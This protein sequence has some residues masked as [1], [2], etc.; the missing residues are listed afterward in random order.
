VGWDYQFVDR[1]AADA[2][3]RLDLK[4]DWFV[5]EGTAFPPPELRRSAVSTLLVDGEQYPAAAYGNRAITLV[6]K[7]KNP[8]DLDAVAAAKQALLRELDR[9]AGIL[10]YRPGTSEPV[11]FRTFRAGPES[12][13]WTAALQTLTAVIPAEPF[14]YGLK[15]SL[16]Q[17]TVYADPAEGVTLNANPFAETDASDWTAFGGTIARSTAQAHQGSASLLLTPSGSAA[18]AEATTSYVPVTAGRQYRLSAWVRCDAAREVRVMVVWSDGSTETGNLGTT[19][20]VAATTWTLIDTVVTAPV[21]AVQG[22][23]AVAMFSTPPASHLL[24]FDE[25]RVRQVGTEGGLHFNVTDVKGD[26]ETPLHLRLST[27]TV[28]RQPVFAVRRRGTPSAMPFVLQA[29]SMT[30]ATDTALAASNDPAMSGAGQNYLRVS[31]ATNTSMVA[32]ASINPWPAAPSGDVRGT[33]R[34]LAR[35]RRNTGSDA[36]NLQ[37]TWGNGTGANVSGDIV[38]L[39]TVGFTDPIYVDLGFVQF[40]TGQ[41]PVTDMSGEVLP[42]RGMQIVLQAQRATGAGSLDIDFLAFV[43]ADDRLMIATIHPDFGG[44]AQILDSARTML[45]GVGSAGEVRPAVPAQIVGGPP[46]VSPGQTN[47][48]VYLPNILSGASA[49][50][51]DTTQVTP[52][53]WP[54]YLH[55]RPVAS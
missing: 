35:V 53:Y 10:R 27:S 9:P 29:E 1:I 34:V 55:V 54:R 48:I 51:T 46:M 28:L 4:A 11:F 31:F 7:A 13:R 37:L 36:I 41:D 33:Y 52:F 39:P 21:G 20:A 25:A 26:V 45:Y 43:P 32:R 18:S 24:Y 15:E 6:L 42:V 2:T 8:A 3:V 47:R 16:P 40:P 22:R 12:I 50:V 38:A 49:A 5:D 19:V 17:V 23:L 30:P 44:T 14:A